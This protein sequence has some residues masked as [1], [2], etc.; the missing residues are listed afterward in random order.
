[1]KSLVVM[2]AGLGYEGLARRGC[3]KMA[4]LEFKPAASVFPAVTCTA[5]ATFRTALEP[6]EHGMTSNGFFS[7]TLMKPAFWEQSAALVAGP[8]IW[9]RARAAGETVGVYFWQQS[10]GEAADFLISPAPIH[11][12]GGGMIMRNYT[13]PAEMGD[14]LDRRC[15]TFPLHRYWGPLASPKVGRQVIANFRAMTAVHEPDYAF[16]YLPTLDYAAQRFGPD[17]AAADAACAEF[18]AQLEQIVAFAER[19]GAALTVCGDYEIAAV[20]QPPALPNATLRRAGLF[21]VRPVAGRAYPDFYASRAFAMCDHEIAHVYVR[22]PEDVETVARVFAETDA[23]ESVEVRRDQV[24]AHAS[25]GE[26]LLVARKGSWCAYPWWSD[27]REAPDWATHIDI[28]N[29]PGYD[30]C[31]LFFDRS[32][33]PKTCQNWSRVKGTHGRRSTVAWASTEARVAGD[34]M[35]ALAASLFVNPGGA[36]SVS[37]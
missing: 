19:T 11:K 18:R 20:D 5:Q 25:A 9:A 17:A 27:R 22:R 16:L 21:A 28:H 36:D 33:P 12:H 4:G 31:E 10:L 1:M 13:Q 35:R 24:W 15:G 3:L 34:S 23:Y 2:A 32:F 26:I 14:I 30:P 29:K 7:R 6:R 37:S 8:R